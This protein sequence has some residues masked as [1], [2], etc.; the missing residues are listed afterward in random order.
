MQCARSGAAK[1]QAPQDMSE[2]F[3]ESVGHLFEQQL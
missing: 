1:R 2:R 3:R